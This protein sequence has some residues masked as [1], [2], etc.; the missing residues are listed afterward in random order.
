[1]PKAARTGK[2]PLTDLTRH[3]TRRWR[4]AAALA[5]LAGVVVA[6]IW[7]V[8]S[9]LFA[10]ASLERLSSL[11]RSWG[12]WAPL[13][14]VLLM[15]LQALVAPV[16]AFL[17]A[18]ANGIVFG[19]AGIL[20][21]FVGALAGAVAAFA[22][23]RALGSLLASMRRRR[24]RIEEHVRRISSGRG[25][26]I[27]LVARL[28]PFVSFDVVSYAAGLSSIPL[29][30][31][32]LAT[33]IGMA[34]ATVIYTVAG[35]GARSLEMSSRAVVLVSLGILLLSFTVWLI[36]RLLT[37]PAGSRGSAHSPR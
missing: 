28:L 19:Y 9:D 15:V 35:V 7:V 34:P 4:I 27:I 11:I 36:R 1:M 14:S 33:L 37:P 8:R 31:F 24:S 3:A 32:L 21:S 29:W 22:I 10:N 18:V 17:I 20:V 2:Q 30:K 16:P 12:L 13:L 25:F 26:V 23:A 6:S 5:I